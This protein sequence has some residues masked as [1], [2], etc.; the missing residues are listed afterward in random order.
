MFQITSST[1]VDGQPP[2][3]LSRRCGREITPRDAQAVAVQKG[4]PDLVVADLSPLRRPA[5]AETIVAA[6]RA[7]PAAS[8]T[9]CPSTLPNRSQHVSGFEVDSV[10][11]VQ[12]PSGHE[13]RAWIRHD[14]SA[15]TLLTAL[16]DGPGWE[17]VFRRITTN[18][19][20]GKLI[21]DKSEQQRTNK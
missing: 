15:S 14:H 10:F 19:R 4:T 8:L 17:Q 18:A 6:L 11:D 2:V 5:D 20:T 16:D 9:S 1:R 3:I 7:L 21:D 12:I 13:A